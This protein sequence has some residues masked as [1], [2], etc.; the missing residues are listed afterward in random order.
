[1]QLQFPHKKIVY[2]HK[3]EIISAR[4]EEMLQ[5]PR[6]QEILTCLKAY[7]KDYLNQEYSEI[8]QKIL[9]KIYNTPLNL[10]WSKAQL[11]TAGIVHAVA[12]LNEIEH[13]E[14]SWQMPL[15]DIATH[16]NVPRQ[17]M[18]V[19]SE[20]IQ[21]R[22]SFTTSC[23]DYLTK[24]TLES[25]IAKRKKAHSR[26]YNPVEY[27]W[28]TYGSE[29]EAMENSDTNGSISVDPDTNKSTSI[30]KFAIKEKEPVM[31]SD[32]DNREYTVGDLIHNDLTDEEIQ[33]LMDFFDDNERYRNN[34]L[35]NE[36]Q[37]TEPKQVTSANVLSF[38]SKK[39]A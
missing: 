28:D 9:E 10:N 33:S 38:R 12:S 18:E 20:A 15:K 14:S 29:I 22:V 4:R 21:K 13:R 26:H 34:F 1:M 7:A 17:A 8:T 36:N 27:Y 24:K 16:F 19:T 30:V 32:G 5:N 37:E 31:E 2:S 3:G 23:S 39:K 11:W 35:P 25:N 6:Y